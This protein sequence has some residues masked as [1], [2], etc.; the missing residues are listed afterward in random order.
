MSRDVETELKL[1]MRYEVLAKAVFYFDRHL[2]QLRE[3]NPLA[4]LL[5]ETVR[6][7]M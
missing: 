6:M 3:L 5:E 4:S 1:W 2:E 7:L